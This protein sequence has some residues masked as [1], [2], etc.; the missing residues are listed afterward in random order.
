MDLGPELKTGRL[1]LR[2]WR[3]SDLALFAALNSDPVVM[4]HFP[5]MLSESET[6]DMIERLDSHFDRHGFGLWAVEHNLSRRFIGFAGLS[7]PR[8]ESH[9]TPAVE[10][11]WRLAKD[12]WGNGFATE[13]AQA[14]IAFGF[15]VA[16]LEEIVSFAIATNVRSVQV[17]E[18]LGMT[19]DPADDFDH[20]MFLEDDRL[21]HHVLYRLTKRRWSETN[22][23]D[24][25]W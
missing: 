20:P 22:A 12:Q 19:H 18:R 13:A 16:D 14:A 25:R 6:A 15:D 10:V 2:R 8:F 11:G 4:E 3:D 5:S 1:T 7:I 17:M 9:F 21:R 23:S 24:R